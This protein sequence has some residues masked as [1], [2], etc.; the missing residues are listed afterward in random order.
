MQEGPLY[1]VFD[2]SKKTAREATN[3]ADVLARLR[4]KH[5]LL[6]RMKHEGVIIVQVAKTAL[7]GSRMRSQALHFRRRD[8]DA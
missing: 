5:A 8:I 2:E 1:E 3:D 7:C 6:K 4:T